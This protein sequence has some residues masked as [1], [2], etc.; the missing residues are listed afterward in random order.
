[1][2]LLT[3]SGT[4]R[5]ENAFTGK[6]LTPGARIGTSA[7]AGGMIGKEVIENKMGTKVLNKTPGI[8][9][10]PGMSY[11]QKTT[12]TMGASGSLTLALSN[13]NNYQNR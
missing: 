9:N 5:F 12:P 8:H 6:K 3:H 2:D 11:D 7:L 10:A 1:M 4:R 13:F